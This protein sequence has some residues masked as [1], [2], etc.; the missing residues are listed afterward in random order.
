ML[1]ISILKLYNFHEPNSQAPTVF[2]EP[3][4]GKLKFENL[5]CEKNYIEKTI[6]IK[7]KYKSTM[8]LL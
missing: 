1:I 5:T 2:K 3:I 6:K 8:K 4:V 7:N